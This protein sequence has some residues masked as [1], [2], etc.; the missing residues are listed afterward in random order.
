M[1]FFT[2]PI[3]YYFNHMEKPLNF[4]EIW[5]DNMFMLIV[6][7]ILWVMRILGDLLHKRINKIGVKFGFEKEY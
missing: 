2:I 1:I 5:E 7:G 4:F 6:F 3:F